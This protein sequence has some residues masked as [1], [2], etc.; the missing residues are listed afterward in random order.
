VLE[1]KVAVTQKEA[2]ATPSDFIAFL[3]R[4]QTGG[5]LTEEEARIFGFGARQFLEQ[6]L[7]EA[8]RCAKIA[9]LARGGLRGSH[10]NPR[11]RCRPPD[12]RCRF[13]SSKASSQS[14]PHVRV[15]SA[16]LPYPQQ[17]K[18]DEVSLGLYSKDLLNA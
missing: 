5:F 4:G 1:G 14:D 8:H 18:R 16:P 17:C 11:K 10:G 3:T 7:R 12:K 15:S 9:H 13:Q 6:P 2:A